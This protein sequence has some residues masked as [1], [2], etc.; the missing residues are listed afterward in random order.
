MDWI[1]QYFFNAALIFVLIVFVAV[2]FFLLRDV[3]VYEPTKEKPMPT[4]N[5]GVIA[6]AG[7][8]SGLLGAQT[9]A[10]LGFIAAA[11]K[12][13]SAGRTTNNPSPPVM[14]YVAGTVYALVGVV[15]AI[16]WIARPTVAPETVTTFAL[17]AFGWILGAASVAL[18]PA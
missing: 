14:A 5:V 9:A 1:K 2:W 10:S 12:L 7:A 18:K 3:V 11:T 4:L 6:F 17:A 13:F 8:V 16:I 15:A